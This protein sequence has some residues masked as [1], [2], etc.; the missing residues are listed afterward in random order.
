MQKWIATTDAQWQAVFKR[1]VSDVHAT[2]LES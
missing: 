1:D 2:E